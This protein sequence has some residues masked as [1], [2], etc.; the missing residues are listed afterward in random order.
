MTQRLKPSLNSQS[1]RNFCL[2]LAKPIF[3]W[4]STPVHAHSH[5]STSAHPFLLEYVSYILLQEALSWLHWVPSNLH[6]SKLSHLLVLPTHSL[7]SFLPSDSLRP[8]SF[9][10]GSHTEGC[11]CYFYLHVA[12]K[13][14]D[15]GIFFFS[16]FC[17]WMSPIKEWDKT[18]VHVLLVP[19]QH[20]LHQGNLKLMGAQQWN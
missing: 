4:V 5:I 8:L 20:S 16:F 1:K 12:E 3:A 17:I 6:F 18:F 15:A 19:G 7:C 9:F 2:F 11:M 10:L 13:K 14:Y